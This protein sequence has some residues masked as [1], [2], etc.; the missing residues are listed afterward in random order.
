MP[1]VEIA[2]RA[3]VP[4]EDNTESLTF[5]Q[6]DD[7]C[8]FDRVLIFDTETTI[9]QYQNLKFGSFKIYDNG[10]QKYLGIFYDP[11]NTYNKELDTLARYCEEHNIP[12]MSVN[13]FVDK[14]F[15]PEAYD[16]KTLVVGFNLP[17]DLSR[18]AKGFGYARN[19]MKGGF[20]FNLS[21]NRRYPR[22]VIKHI[23]ST[24]AFIRFGN[25]VDVNKRKLGF[26]GNFL[27]LHTL[28]YALTGESHS[29]GSACEVL[30]TDVPKLHTER[31]GRI[32]TEYIDYNLRDLNAT[33]SLY[34]KAKEGFEL[35]GLDIPITK[36][37]SSA[38]IGKAYFKM[39]SIRP[40]LSKNK[41]ISN[42]IL[43]HVTSTYFGGRSEVRIRKQPMPITLLDFT[44]MYP[45]M[46]TL[47]HLW[48][49]ITCD[50][51][52]EQECTEEIVKFL[53][54]VTLKDFKRQETFE[55]LNAIVQIEPN[56]DI[57]P[58]RCKFGT[59]NTYN[60]A[61]PFVTTNNC[62]IR[63]WYALADVVNSKLRNVKMP[64]VIRAI[65]FVA[66][67]K[68]Q[69]LKPIVLFDKTIDPQKDNLFKAIIEKRKRLQ[70]ECKKC[71]AKSR[72]KILLDKKQKALKIVANATSYGI[73]ME[74]NT[75]EKETNVIAYGLETMQCH[76]NKLE[77]FGKQA[78]SIVATFI[79]SGARLV[80]G[81]VEAILSKHG[82]VH[83]FCDTDSMAVPPEYTKE[84]QEFF[85]ALNPYNFDAPL[86]KVEEYEDEQGQKHPLENVLF[87]G[88]SA[89][90][91]V[92]YRRDNA[93]GKIEIVKASSHG[94]GHLLNP[95]TRDNGDWY[96]QVWLD[97]LKFHYGQ[98]SI[99]EINEKY[100]GSYALTKLAISTPHIMKRFE[101]L[102]KN[103]CYDRQI[104]PFNF[105]I[106]GIGNVADH[107]TGNPVR[108][109]APFRRNVQQCAYDSFIDYESGKEMKGLQYWKPFADV[110][111]DYINHPEAK[112][113]GD[114]GVLSRKHVVVNSVMHIGKESNNL[115]QTE[116]LGAHDDDYV[117][118]SR[119]VAC[120]RPYADK[121]LQAEPKDVR[122]FGISQQT[123]YNIKRAVIRDA[124]QRISQR[125]MRQL[126]AFISA[127]I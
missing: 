43:G 34:V 35:Y 119:D 127:C 5:S 126:L 78:N 80:L 56:N 81:I 9:D 83:A 69:G 15:L 85:T 106:A 89:K 47:M 54:N 104:K 3:Y 18:V 125:T 27:D 40:F 71:N 91:Y 16:L 84:I 116:A 107:E 117:V 25:S 96:K 17:F 120:L 45:T 94:L 24:K 11:E 4:S 50:H 36:I 58:I 49:F 105:C 76:V 53:E 46:C 55:K 32:T 73:F 52:E 102:N 109:L 1:S 42:E 10:C 100:E 48:D 90:R 30:D 44:S 101:C 31:H 22:L 111:W 122:K 112:F 33:Y 13:D 72:N 68:Q 75:Y 121:I 88:I 77:Q 63:P 7:Q 38:S 87:Y 118:Y 57:L 70:Q 28:V 115:E 12:L 108:P 103:K 99:E 14:F 23:D 60:I 113:D 19:G 8:R 98:T 86:F 21:D 110:F 93:S 39:M 74:I 67:E 20:S 37:Y 124:W 82:A 65:R 61:D 41:T 97:I 123:L 26:R 2:I 114:I 62:K 6:Q 51:I 64:K 59:K 95:F 92:L 66:K 79:T 29:L